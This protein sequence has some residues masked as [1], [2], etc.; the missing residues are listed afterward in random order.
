MKKIVIALFV[1]GVAAVGFLS[2]SNQQGNGP[3]PERTSSSEPNASSGIKKA[4]AGRSGA[5]SPQPAVSDIDLLRTVLERNDFYDV[6]EIANKLSQALKEYP[7]RLQE[8]LDLLRTE[9][10]PRFLNVIAGIIENG[11]ALKNPLLAKTALDLAQED[12]LPARRHTALALLGKLTEVS[13]ETSKAVVRLSR[14]A[15]DPEV[16]TSAIAAM[17]NWMNAQPDR[18]IE[19]NRELLGTINAS[20]APEVRANALQTIGLH[21]GE[22]PQTFT[23]SIMDYMQTDSE[24]MNR[25]LAAR[26]LARAPES[27]RSAT[28]DRLHGAFESEKDA[29]VRRAILNSVVISSTQDAGAFLSRH[30]NDNSISD[31]VNDYLAI[32]SAGVTEPQEIEDRKLAL[33]AKRTGGAVVGNDKH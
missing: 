18:S 17:A 10:N 1:C 14:Q 11:D 9:T 25:A 13:P 23:T 19:L 7:E 3:S 6:E 21:L 20:T 31:D 4:V 26:L 28:M 16:R 24:P 22:L 32:L 27:M 15:T 12:S 2:I 5:A 8:F 33:E 30:V 29:G